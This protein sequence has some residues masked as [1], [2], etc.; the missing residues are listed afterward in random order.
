MGLPILRELPILPKLNRIKFNTLS[1][2]PDNAIFHFVR[3]AKDNGVDIFR[4]FD[5]LNNIDNLEV[6]I[7]AVLE[8]GGVAEGAI[9]YTED[10]MKPGKYNLAYYMNIVD[11]LVAIG[12]HIIAFKSMSGVLKPKAGSILVRSVR[13]RYPSTPIHMHTHDN[14]GAGVATMMACAEAGADIVDTA[15]DS[16][17]GTTS[18]P[19]VSSVLGALEDTGRDAEI[20]LHEVQAIDS[21]WA[22]VRLLYAG[23]DADLRSPDPDIYKHEIPGGQFSNLMFQARQL[24]LGTQWAETKHAYVEAN[25]LLG[26]IIK[27]TPTSKAVG[28]LAQFM[29]DRSLTLEDVRRDAAN[30]DLPASVLDFFEGLMGQPFDGFPEPLRTNALRGRRR[31][32]NCRPGLLIPPVDLHRVRTDLEARYPGQPITECDIASHIMYPDVYAAYRKCLAKYGNLSVLPTRVFLTAPKPGEEISIV[33]EDGKEIILKMVAIGEMDPESGMRDVYF[34]L[35][36][37]LRLVA[38]LDKSGQ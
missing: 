7:R 14:N 29:V 34:E 21:Y 27:A 3:S 6:G 35:N 33:I 10:M 5:C 16:I 37:E 30:L 19:A 13:E 9:L 32:M 20:H 2:L 26:N 1:R 38:V 18:Q 17:S 11:K 4:V 15:T 31:K 12:A 24:G 23:F 25:A 28:D 22:Q 8:A 36:G